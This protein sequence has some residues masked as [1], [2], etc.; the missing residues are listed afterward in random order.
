MQLSEEGKND[1]SE[2]EG[3][4]IRVIWEETDFAILGTLLILGYVLLY[5]RGWTANMIMSPILLV[6]GIT[7]IIQGWIYGGR[8]D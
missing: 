7:L 1:S 3:C 5:L 6:V 4:F 8:N 2:Q